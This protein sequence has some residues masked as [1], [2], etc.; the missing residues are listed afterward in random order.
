[1]EELIKNRDEI[2]K[3]KM[4]LDI[5]FKD[6]IKFQMFKI[7]TSSL[8]KVEYIPLYAYLFHIKHGNKIV[9]PT[10]PYANR[11]VN[12]MD[13][14]NLFGNSLHYSHVISKWNTLYRLFGHFAFDRYDRLLGGIFI[15]PGKFD[16]PF[17]NLKIEDF[18][19]MVDNNIYTMKDFAILKKFYGQMLSAYP[20]IGFIKMSDMRNFVFK[21]ENAVSETFTSEYLSFN[22]EQK[23]LEEQDDIVKNIFNYFHQQTN[24]YYT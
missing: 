13:V 16:T 17:D 3:M 6:D 23:L 15:N 12:K 8:Q 2:F 19:I 1:M 9:V 4:N 7:N 10:I 21:E 24:V 18:T 20:E 11:N 14:A 22:Q 5:Y